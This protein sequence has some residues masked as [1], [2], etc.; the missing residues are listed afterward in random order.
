MVLTADQ[1]I[2]VLALV[3]SLEA[4]DAPHLLLLV[5][6]GS[7]HDAAEVMPTLKARGDLS[8]TEFTSCLHK[9]PKAKH[10][11]F[12]GQHE[13]ALIPELVEGRELH[14]LRLSKCIGMTDV[15]GLAGCA[16]LHTLDL[17]WCSRV[18]DVSALARCA[19][20][21]TLDLSYGFRVTDVSALARCASLHTLND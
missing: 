17:S 4:L 10:L 19:S 14:T 5:C 6:K 7:R 2:E 13:E 20:L 11:S 21:H 8:W 3:V 15:S 1:Q 12:S 9:F 16:N 18:T